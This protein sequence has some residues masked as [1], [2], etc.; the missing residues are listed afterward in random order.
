[1]FQNSA[2]RSSTIVRFNASE[3]VDIAVTDESVPIQHYLRQPQRLVWTIANP[4]LIEQIDANRFSVKVR[5]ISFMDLYHFQPMSV[6]KVTADAAATLSVKSEECA[7]LGN[8][9]IN[10][11]FTMELRG[12]LA[13]K[14]VEGRTHLHGWASLRVEVD[15]PPALFLVPMPA[16]EAAGN[17]LLKGVL[18]RI[19]QRLL[20]QLLA[21]YR[22]WATDD[23]PD[24]A[25]ANRV[26]LR[27]AENPSS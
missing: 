11:R 26:G 14:Q 4:K 6:L 7:V 5:P 16:I 8:D 24:L 2:N 13:P 23:S 27:T 12:K 19:K 21:D 22:A 1:M 9:F 25:G 20:A 10:D 18:Q 15:L 3:T 17:S